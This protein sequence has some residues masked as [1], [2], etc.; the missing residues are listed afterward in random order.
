MHYSSLFQYFFFDLYQELIE[1]G[2][3]APVYAM[4]LLWL[5]YLNQAHAHIPGFLIASV[6]VFVCM[7]IY[8]FVF[9][10]PREQN[11]IRQKQPVYNN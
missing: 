6:C 10:H 7:F 2:G 1:S 11:N 9:L 8:M 3:R 4:S 5:Q